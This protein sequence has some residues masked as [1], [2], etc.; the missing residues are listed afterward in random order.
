MSHLPS[1]G[2]RGEGWVILQFLLLPAVAFAG[3]VDPLALD[4]ILADVGLVAGL[5]LIALGALL[6]GRGLLDL[7]RNLTPVPH[8]RDGAQLVQSGVYAR[9]R[10]PIYGGLMLMAV[11]WG[12]VSASPLTLVLAGVLA[13]FFGLKSRREEAWLLEHY[14]GYAEYMERTRRFVPYLG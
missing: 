1:L 3:L 5:A 12:L 10:H 6:G 2:P 8:P 14:A 11:G 13:L 9:A 4:G 7:G